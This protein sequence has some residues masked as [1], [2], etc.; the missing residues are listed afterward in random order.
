MSLLFSIEELNHCTSSGVPIG[1]AVKYFEP[2]WFDRALKGPLKKKDF[3]KQSNWDVRVKKLI[4]RE[5]SFGAILTARDA[6]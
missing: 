1:N 2:R 4:L 3:F 5:Y 6:I